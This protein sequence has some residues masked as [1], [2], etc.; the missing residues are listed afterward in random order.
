M[1]RTQKNKATEGHLGALKAKLAKL[2]NELLVE[3]SGGGG[4]GEGFDVARLGDARVAFIGFPSVGKSTLLGALTGTESEAAAYEFTTLTCIPGTMRY[5]GSKVQ[6]LDLPGIIEGAAHGKGRGREV[7]AVARNADMILIVLD[8]GKEGLNRHREILE[9]EL[10][11]VGIRLN[12]RPPDVTL[13]KKKTGGVRFASTIPLTK[14]GPDPEKVAT[15]ILREY[16]ITNADLL[17]REDITVDQLVDVVQGNRQYKP[18]L[19]LYN[20]IDTITIEEVD[21]LARMPH[22][23]VGSVNL[24][25]NIGEPDEDDLLKSKMWEYLGLTRIYTKR[26]GQPPD[27]EDPVILSEIRKGT[28]VESLCANVSTQMLRD[29]NYALVWGTSAKHSPQR[30]GLKHD[31][32]DED[33]VQIVTKTNVQQRQDKKYQAMVQGFSDKYHKKKFDA[34]KQKQKKLR[35]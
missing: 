8:A 33:V 15:Q 27:L 1:A 26:R 17:A 19:Y 29:F 16:K 14:L 6:V 20:K 23:V 3:Q 21:Q 18:C 32:D 2:R 4:G 34:K 11:T 7:I 22:S 13:T 31:L 24:K 28:T 12:Q 30:C 25:M 5:K 35:G 10:E 9:K